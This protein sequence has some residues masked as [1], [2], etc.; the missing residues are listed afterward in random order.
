MI[1]I[2]YFQPRTPRPDQALDDRQYAAAHCTHTHPD[3]VATFGTLA[4]FAVWCRARAVVGRKGDAGYIIGGDCTT[5][6]KEGG[7]AHVALID[8]DEGAH[9]PDWAAL[10]EYE[11][12]AWTT[13]SHS[14]TKPS[15]RVVI[16]FVEPLAHGK[17]RCPFKGGH[18]RNRTQ[19]AFLPTHGTDLAHVEWRWLQGTKRLD[20][21]ELGGEAKAFIARG[22][23][24]LGA[25]FEAA[26][27]VIG[28]QP[29]A[30]VVRCPWVHLHSDGGASGSVVFHADPD[31]EGFGKFYCSRTECMGKGWTSQQ[32]LEQIKGLPAVAHELAHWTGPSL[33]GYR[34]LD[35]PAVPSAV[36]AVAALLEP[37]Q[38]EPTMVSSPDAWVSWMNSKHTVL[39]QVG[40]KCRVVAWH[41]NAPMLQTFE[42]FKRRYLNL[43]ALIEGCVD[44]DGNAKP[45][46]VGDWWLKHTG[47]DQA[48]TMCFRPDLGERIVDGCLNTW[49]GY[50]VTPKVGSWERMRAFID[51]V[52]ASENQAHLD[53]IM[54]WVTWVVQNPGRRA[55]VVLVL[56]GR[57]GTGK[58]TLFDALCGLF[59]K[60][61]KTVSN[62]KHLT[63]NFNAHLQNCAFLFANEALPPN[64]KPSEQVMKALIT[65][66][67][68]AIERKGVDVET[69]DNVLSIGMAS[70]EGWCVPAGLD[71]RRFAVF[72]ISDHR[73]QDQAYFGAIHAE[74]ASGGLE[75][76]L[77]DLL[78]ADLGG[79]HPRQSVP[80]TRPLVEQQLQSLR[81]PDRVV[82]HML[83]DGVN[84]GK[85]KGVIANPIEGR[86]FV[87]TRVAVEQLRERQSF[88]TGLSLALARCC[89]DNERT[90][91]VSANS[92][93]FGTTRHRGRWL[94]ALAEARKRWAESTRLHVEWD[95]AT[96][97][98]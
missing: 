21:R 71:E 7:P 51:E 98:V 73:I 18:I 81:G 62:P 78:A 96:E 4:E 30:L 91:Q 95:D 38:P 84:P 94:P 59:G 12:F 45:V 16:P 36:P 55:E 66:S 2:T 47:R 83:A 72:D 53:Y 24:L 68:I 75:A 11:G 37:G 41:E 6:R 8:Q 10:D 40:G 92:F 48:L 57:R 89:P 76:M 88:E 34:R 64:D 15:W 52:V 87:C 27:L 97:W 28:E 65:D 50:S 42:D 22:S 58:N 33:D 14:P 49:T 1:H 90:A 77:H 80:N 29:D 26:G 70:N 60:H 82:Y 32:A 69:Q 31:D 85:L 86:E 44:K 39:T 67:T 5:T 63:G 79:W 35:A 9:A 23:S 3:H 17:L 25:A 13:A 54:R 46:D 93:G 43:R 61:G 74:L 20:A 56:R 19:P